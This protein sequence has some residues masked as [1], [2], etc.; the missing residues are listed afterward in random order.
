[1]Q[2][3]IFNKRSCLRVLAGV[4]LLPLFLVCF[5]L[6]VPP[7]DLPLCG[8]M[9]AL[10]AAG[11]VLARHESRAWRTIWTIALILSILGGI[12]QIVAGQRLAR[13]RSGL[14]PSYE[15]SLL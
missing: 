15:M 8:L 3:I 2:K 14:Q 4:Y 13:Q 9:L 7:A 6:S 12:L 5:S 11:L 1:M 10:A